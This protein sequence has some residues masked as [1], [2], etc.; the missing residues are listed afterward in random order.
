[1][2]VDNSI[3]AHSLFFK[4]FGV[5]SATGEVVYISVY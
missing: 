5:A 1:M 3:I 4:L 2:T